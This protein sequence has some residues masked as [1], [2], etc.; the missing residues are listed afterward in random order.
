MHT[1]MSVMR[2]RSHLTPS[3]PSEG[4]LMQPA[5]ITLPA[6]PLAAQPP[7]FRTRLA[8]IL[9]LVVAM[10]LAVIVVTGGSARA[11][12][13]LL[14]QGKPATASSTENAGTPASAAVDGNLTATRWSSAFTDPQWLQV[15]LGAS[16]TI[17]QVVLTWE[18][19]YAKSF[20]IQTSPDGVTWTSIYTTTTGAGGT[21]TLN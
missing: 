3:V 5:P 11:A 20:Q 17:S 6:R 7:G 8:V 21:Q 18:A 15:D 16:A 1:Q 10:V 2:A 12:G 13:T 4:E 14:S 19:A 9:G